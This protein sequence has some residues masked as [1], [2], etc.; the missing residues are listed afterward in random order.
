MVVRAVEA[1]RIAAAAA[2]AVM[3]SISPA[4]ASLVFGFGEFD[5][6]N[7]FAFR[8]ARGQHFFGKIRAHVFIHDLACDAQDFGVER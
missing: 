2:G 8:P 7:L 1:R 3:R 4:P 6:A 5:D